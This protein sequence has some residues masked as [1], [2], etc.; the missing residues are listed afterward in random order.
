[1]IISL[2][3]THCTGKTTLVKAMMEDPQLK[4][5]C[6]FINA[7]GK[8]TAKYGLSINEDGDALSQ[9]FF[10]TR[11]LT[12]LIENRNEKKHLICDRSILDVVVYSRYLGRQGKIGLETIQLVE[13]LNAIESQL[14]DAYF[15]LEP[16][17]GL[18][19]EKDRSMNEKF[20]KDIQS[21]FTYTCSFLPEGMKEGTAIKYL[22]S[23]LQSRMSLIKNFLGY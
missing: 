2:S 17:F 22:P 8:D 11:Q 21:L 23:D 6:S 3:G 1:M 19:E 12:R 14:M 15:I 5:D 20:Q 9:V 16:S 18:V 4:E 10:A 13:K 7:S